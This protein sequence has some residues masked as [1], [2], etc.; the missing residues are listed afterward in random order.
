MALRTGY[1]Q[2]NAI[3][4]VTTPFGADVLLLDSLHGEEGISRLFQFSLSMRS[5][6]TSLAMATIVGAS[7]TA[8]VTVPG[9]DTRYVNGIVSRFVHVGGNAD[10]THYVA[11]V[12][13]RLWT[14]TLGRDRV[15]YQNKSATDIIKAVLGDFSVT[16]DDKTTGTYTAREYCVRYDETAFDFISRLMEEEGIFYFF[17]FA[18]GSHTMVL[19]DATSAHTACASTPALKVRADALE[20]RVPVDEVTRFE[21][22]GRL[23]TKDQLIGDYDFETPSTSL[24]TTSVGTAGKGADYVFPGGHK[25]VADGTARA[26]IFVE[27][28]QVES[29]RG[30]GEAVSPFLTAGAKITLSQHL[31]DALN[32]DHVLRSVSHRALGGTYSNSFETFDATVPFRAPRVTPRPVAIGSHTAL[33]VGSS[34]EEIWTDKYGRIKVQFYWDRVGKKDQDSSCWVRVTQGWAGQGW[35]NLFLPRVGQEVIVGY[36]DGNPDR[37]IV[38]GSVYNAEQTVPV[39][40]PDNQ[41]QSVMRSRSSKTGTAGNE[42][43]FEDK[44][45]SEQLFMHAQKDMKVDIEN[46]LA[47]TLIKGSETHTITEGDRTIAVS[48]GKETH[49][50]KDTRAVTVTGDETHTNEAKFTHEVTGDYT[51]TIKGKLTINV[52]GAIAI[53]GSA[54]VDVEAGTA[55]TNKSGTALTNQAGTALTNKA[56]TD[57]TNQAGMGLTNKAGTTLEN[58][59]LMVNN[60]A[61]ATQTV[62]GGGMLTLKG[63]LVKIN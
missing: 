12:V 44:K 40:L 20:G 53:K 22:D 18:D 15:I 57:L 29:S 24:Q 47:T 54:A 37:P 42:M 43:R 19:A 61:S 6:S 8:K 50:V 14:L 5:S 7:A 34:G 2:D 28:Q 27:A 10:F 26:K 17:T 32:T 38:T 30:Y 41:T 60:K 13:P 33:V 31:R 49:T 16:F 51:L 58:S 3:L 52:T 36:V 23:V 56:G 1:V 21:L 4:S 25:V 11:E 45:D 55:L 39:T 62:D 46:D 63:G 59:G 35:G 9:G 48:K